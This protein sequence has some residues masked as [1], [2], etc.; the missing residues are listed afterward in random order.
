MFR[1]VSFFDL[2]LFY[3]V[4]NFIWY[5]DLRGNASFNLFRS[6]RLVLQAIELSLTE[7]FQCLQRNVTNVPACSSLPT[8]ILTRTHDEPQVTG[9]PK[10]AAEDTTI[11]ASNMR[12]EKKVIPVLKGT[13][14]VIDTSGIHYNRKYMIFSLIC[15]SYGMFSIQLVTGMTR[16]HSTLPVFSKIG[17]VMPFCHLVL[18]RNSFLLFSPSDNAFR[19]TCVHWTKVCIFYSFPTKAFFLDQRSFFV[20]LIDSSRLKA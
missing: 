6:V 9:I 20:L 17:L 14:V 1:C 15:G 16:I 11:V 12:G 19:S 4:L 7:L 5:L 3:F 13:D 8:S 18:V 10:V 2:I